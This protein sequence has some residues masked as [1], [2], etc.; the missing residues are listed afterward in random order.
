[1]RTWSALAMLVP[2]ALMSASAATIRGSIVE[3]HTGSPVASAYVTISQ[4]GARYYAVELETG[5]EGT[6]DAPDLLP[7]DYQIEISR[8]GYVPAKVES[9]RLGNTS[10]STT[11][12][13]VRGGVIRGRVTDSQDKP[14]G[15]V[16]VQAV[17]KST[18]PLRQDPNGPVSVSDGTGR[19][20]LYN[21]PPG[22][23]VV[24]AATRIIGPGQTPFSLVY[25]EA[26]RPRV[27]SVSGG[28]D[29]IRT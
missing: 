6:F 10:F 15:R 2:A 23:Y 3:D 13:L 4:P 16:A 29:Y 26:A 27:F 24:L 9:V 8:S 7:G 22:E 12:R 25:P 21:V 5:P 14:V 17:P 19:Y 20:R 18:V 1:M 11:V 28:E